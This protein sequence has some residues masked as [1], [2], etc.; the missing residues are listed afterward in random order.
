MAWSRNVSAGVAEHHATLGEI[1]ASCN[2]MTANDAENL[3]NTINSKEK[4]EKKEKKKS[5]PR[6]GKSKID[7][8]SR[9]SWGGKENMRRRGDSQRRG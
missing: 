6:D 1:K 7:R 3:H 4:E 2:S 5:K 9:G 8:R